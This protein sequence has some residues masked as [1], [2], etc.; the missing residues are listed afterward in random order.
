MTAQTAHSPE[1]ISSLDEVIRQALRTRVPADMPADEALGT[2]LR[3]QLGL[4]T[5]S[6]VAALFN[7]GVKTLREWRYTGKG[8][9]FVQTPKK[10][11]YRVVD[12]ARYLEEEVVVP[13]ADDPPEELRLGD[14]E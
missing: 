3:H 5:P 7:V 14:D 13:N 8:P 4:F 1:P 11:F 12:I 2:T 10:I 9:R 6:E